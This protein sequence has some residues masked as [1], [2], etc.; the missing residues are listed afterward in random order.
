MSGRSKYGAWT[1]SGLAVFG[2]LTFLASRAL[3]EPE[4]P[5]GHFH[6]EPVALDEK[7]FHLGFAYEG[8]I[9]H[10][11]VEMT[12]SNPSSFKQHWLHLL[13]YFDYDNAWNGA[14]KIVLKHKLPS[15]TYVVELQS[16]VDHLILPLYQKG[17]EIYVSEPFIPL[18]A[19]DKTTYTQLVLPFECSPGHDIRFELE[20]VLVEP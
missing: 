11:F 3:V 16:D 19:K 12:L 14:Y 8:E 17:S 2:L 1:V 10:T 15:S 9:P 18:N 4:A 6:H 13:D 20:K 5:T 7:D